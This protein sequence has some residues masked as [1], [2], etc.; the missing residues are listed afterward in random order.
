[1]CY[2]LIFKFIEAH[3]ILRHCNYNTDS[4]HHTD[5]CQ[6]TQGQGELFSISES[7]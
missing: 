7:H 1:M 5:D 3:T 2:I 6:D 4:A